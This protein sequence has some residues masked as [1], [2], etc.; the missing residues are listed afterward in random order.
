ML[1][2]SIMPA[3]RAD[4]TGAAADA[5]KIVSVQY[6]RGGDGY[7]QAYWPDAR[8]ARLLVPDVEPLGDLDEQ[9]LLAAARRSRRAATMPIG[10]SRT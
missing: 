6:V 1:M 4:G 8:R 2:R 7:G 5:Q 10:M 9:A 3:A